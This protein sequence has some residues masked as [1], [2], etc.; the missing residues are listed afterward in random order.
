MPTPTP[1]KKH[2]GRPHKDAATKA[3]GF[4]CKLYPWEI[5]K[6]NSLRGEQ[7]AGRFFAQL[8]SEHEDKTDAP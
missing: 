4:N 3:K 7:S 2:A 1:P 8:M 5:E 6:L